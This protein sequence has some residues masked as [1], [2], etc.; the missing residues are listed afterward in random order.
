[1]LRY[2]LSFIA[3]SFVVA[4]GG[5]EAPPP[6][7][8]TT[9]RSTPA[10]IGLMNSVVVCQTC[11]PELLAAKTEGIMLGLMLMPNYLGADILPEHA[12]VTFHLDGDAICGTAAQFKATHSYLTGYTTFD[13]HGKGHVCLFDVEKTNRALPFTAE[14]ARLLEDQLLPIHEAG[15]V[16]FAGREPDY[17]IQEP[18]VKAVSFILSGSIP[19]PCKGYRV[20]QLPDRL[21][22]DLC[23]AGMKPADIPTILAHT[24]ADAKTMARP[25]TATEFADEVASVINADAET[26]FQTDHVF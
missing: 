4:C 11:A 25:L 24:A 8:G 26:I 6:E 9:G 7:T 19:D 5:Q 3:L 2:A 16:W 18:F 20:S 13:S 14:N 10:A 21:L 22:M 12:P 17:S 15:H 23:D 1:M